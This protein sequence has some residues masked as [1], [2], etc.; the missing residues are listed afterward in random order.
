MTPDLSTS[1]TPTKRR[2]LPWAIAAGVAALALTVGIVIGQSGGDTSSTAKVSTKQL[3]SIR[4]ACNQWHSSSAS[5]SGPSDGWCD[6]MVGW[7]TDEVDHGQMMG[8]AMWSNPSQMAATCK[9]WASS[10]SGSSSDWC[11]QMTTWMQQHMGNW[12]QWDHGWMMNGDDR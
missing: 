7:M 6:Q 3:A 1:P 4:Q 9:R 11:D 5:A 10:Q 2:W 12:D 8:S